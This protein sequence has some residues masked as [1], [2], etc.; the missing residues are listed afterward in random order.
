M[1]RITVILFR[2]LI[3]SHCEFVEVTNNEH[4]TNTFCQPVR[5]SLMTSMS[6][7]TGNVTNIEEILY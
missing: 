7:N 4:V 6:L 2:L 5:V 1:I 3:L